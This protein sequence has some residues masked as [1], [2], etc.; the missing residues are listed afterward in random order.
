MYIEQH[1]SN[2]TTVCND[3]IRICGVAACINIIP[4]HFIAHTIKARL[5]ISGDGK[6]R[7]IYARILV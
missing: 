2:S 4:V 1:I 5:H 3:I 6:C 7:R